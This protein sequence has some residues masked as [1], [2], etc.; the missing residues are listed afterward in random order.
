M[1]GK[2]YKTICPY[3]Y[4]NMLIE[5]LKH[6]QQGKTPTQIFITP[7]HPKTPKSNETKCRGMNYE[8]APINIRCPPL[9]LKTW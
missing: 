7:G 6:P 4:I 1:P 9:I 8:N 3:T 2:F 5:V